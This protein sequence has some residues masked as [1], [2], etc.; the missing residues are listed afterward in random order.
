MASQNQMAQD[1]HRNVTQFDVESIRNLANLT[2]SRNFTSRGCSLLMCLIYL[3]HKLYGFNEDLM[4][5]V[6][7]GL[8]VLGGV[9]IA[10]GVFS[11]MGSYDDGITE[12]LTLMYCEFNLP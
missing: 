1:L 2:S 4:K 9:G 8:K 6:G 7:L 12:A 11:L 10:V 3:A 5:V